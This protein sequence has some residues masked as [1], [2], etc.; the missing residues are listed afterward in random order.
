MDQNH[1]G[2]K[3]VRYRLYIHS[4]HK[5]TYDRANTTFPLSFS[6]I[7][8]SYYPPAFNRL[9]CRYY[10]PIPASLGPVW[11]GLWQKN[12]KTTKLVPPAPTSHVIPTMS[13][14]R[15]HA[16]GD[17]ESLMKRIHTSLSLPPLS[18]CQSVIRPRTHAKICVDRLFRPVTGVEGGSSSCYIMV[19][20]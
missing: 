3:S 18:L 17:R 8:T 5:K 7:N 16:G 2:I 6:F 10:P 11:D 1:P 4:M 12:K 14:Y 19:L 15:T 13:L 9:T 20:E